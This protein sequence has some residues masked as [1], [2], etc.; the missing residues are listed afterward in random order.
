MSGQIGLT[1]R[2]GSRIDTLL[3]INAEFST[4]KFLQIILIG[5]GMTEGKKWGGK[6]AKLCGKDKILNPFTKKILKFKI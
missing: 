6:K 5:G 4:K 2:V 3:E 1:R